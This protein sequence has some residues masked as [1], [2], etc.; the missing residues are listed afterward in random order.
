MWAYFLHG[1]VTKKKDMAIPIM[2]FFLYDKGG[3]L[4]STFFIVYN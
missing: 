3:V 1:I 4:D 2:F